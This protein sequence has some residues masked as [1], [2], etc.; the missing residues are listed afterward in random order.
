M[1]TAVKGTKFASLKS[2]GGYPFPVADDLF[3]LRDTY[4]SASLVKKGHVEMAMRPEHLLE[5]IKCRENPLY[6]AE[7]YVR[8]ISLDKGIVPFKMFAFQKRMLKQYFENRFSLTVTAR[9][10]GKTTIVAAFILWYAMFHA[11][12]EC[13]ILANKGAQAQEVVTRIRRMYEYLPFFLQA[14][15]TV[16]NKT[17]ITFDN[18][19]S[20]FSAA[21]SSDSIRGH[22][23]ALLYIDEA[24]FIENDA[25]FYEST[26]PVITSGDTSRVI[27]T[28]TP[29]GKRGMFYKLYF[30]GT[31]GA[32]DYKVLTVKW[33]HHPRRDNA[34][35]DTTVRNTSKQ[36]FAQEFE[37]SFIGSSGT[38]IDSQALQTMVFKNPINFPEL[39]A[40][41]GSIISVAPDDEHLFIYENYDPTKKYVAVADPSEGLGLDYSVITVFDVTQIPYR[42]VAKYRNNY[43]S[44][45]L[46]PHTIVSLAT[47][48]GKC[49]VL[50]ES[51]NAC[52]GQVSYILYYELEYENTVLT[53]PDPKGRAAQAEGRSAQPGVK[54]SVK[55]KSIGCANLK[56]LIENGTLIVND[57]HIVEELGTFIQK[58]KSYEADEDCHDDTVMTLVLFSW[59]VKQ[60]F[61]KDYA[62]SDIG[63]F[64][65]DKNRAEIEE[66]ILPFGFIDTTGNPEDEEEAPEIFHHG[67]PVTVGAASR[68][69]EW[70]R[71]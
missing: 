37:C 54:T 20:I 59:F 40:E 22:A 5:L 49:P 31:Q 46:F 66:E 51:N 60:D 47:E 7:N 30:D 6:F 19:S 35:R 17:S 52:G 71:S 63:K 13:A 68:L 14:G 43:I 50:V 3:P 4:P 9:Q 15:A 67:I 41:D 23:V 8:I 10:M 42:V 32:N 62:D 26:Y 18:N 12:K 38:L 11:D 33:D 48:Y 24:A 61:F 39:E 55:V 70:M 45:L 36:Q 2:G 56:T 1:A 44:P 27:M 25:N 57:C 28:S 64:L 65:F 21:T 53:K 69:D 58:G 16:Y 34:W 29:K